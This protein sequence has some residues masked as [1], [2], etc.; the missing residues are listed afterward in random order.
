MKGTKMERRKIEEMNQF[1]IIHT[2]MEMSQG[3]SLC[4][5][6]K[7]KLHFFMKTE[8]SGTERTLSGGIGTSGWGRMWRQVIRG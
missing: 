3:N 5:Y 8:N 6:L 2:Y 7:Q 1:G 4:N